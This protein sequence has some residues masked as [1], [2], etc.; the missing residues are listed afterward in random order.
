MSEVFHSFYKTVEGGEGKRCKYPTRLDVYGC[1][2]FH[3]CAYCY[4]KSLL[5]F[6]K[7][8]HPNDPHVADKSEVIK[9]LDTVKK[10]TILRLG[11]LTDPFQPCE[12]DHHMNRWLIQELNR[13]GIGYL[14]VTKG[15][16]I[17]EKNIDVLNKDLAHI[18]ISY[19]HSEGWAPPGFEHA[20]PPKDRIRVAELLQEQGFD[21]ALRLS[22][23]MPQ[24]IDMKQIL[25]CKVDKIQVEFLRANAMIKKKMPYYDFT[26]WNKKQD[27]YQQLSLS[28]KRFLIKPL[29][30]MGK[31]VSVC[32]DYLPHYIYFRDNVN[33]NKED[34]CNLTLH[35]I[36]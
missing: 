33:Q 11:G 7:N 6:R 20:S 10:G 4:A 36:D 30:D 15:A 31:Q 1:G 12:E 35:N 32:E 34:C 17:L 13:R 9:T 28:A 24:Y 21:V 8:W 19:T 18:Q 16:N 25:N 26:A 23:F 14:I 29:L 5:D 3:D 22:P 27:G 2:C